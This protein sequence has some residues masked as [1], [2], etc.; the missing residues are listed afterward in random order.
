MHLQGNCGKQGEQSY[1]LR[2]QRIMVRVSDP[3]HIS[4]TLH[5][6][7]QIQCLLRK[8][9]EELLKFFVLFLLEGDVF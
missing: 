6:W 2:N 3:Y 8:E 4:L 5:L 9:D 1:R 7:K